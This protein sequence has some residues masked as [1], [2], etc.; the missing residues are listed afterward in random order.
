VDLH[1]Q[2]RDSNCAIYHKD[3]LQ[4]GDELRLREFPWEESESRQ[5]PEELKYLGIK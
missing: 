1:K 2:A 5:L 3:N 4:L